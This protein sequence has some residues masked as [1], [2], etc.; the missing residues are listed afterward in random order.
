VVAFEGNLG[1]SDR[2]PYLG[3]RMSK[4]SHLNAI[5]PII[6]IIRFSESST[7]LVFAFPTVK[8]ERV[9]V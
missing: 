5:L 8:K 2:H 7:L 1:R 9:F 3:G 4:R 6:V